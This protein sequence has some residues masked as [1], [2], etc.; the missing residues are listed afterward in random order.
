MIVK[1]AKCEK[2]ETP[3]VHFQLNKAE[4]V[5]GQCNSNDITLE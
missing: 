5:L 3:S 2:I 1:F 4:N